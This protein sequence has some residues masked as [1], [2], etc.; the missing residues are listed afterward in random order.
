VASFL[1]VVIKKRNGKM[2]FCLHVI[3]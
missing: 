2:I 3:M 1:P